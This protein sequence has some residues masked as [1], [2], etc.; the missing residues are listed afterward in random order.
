M[1]MT[2]S[3]DKIEAVLGFTVSVNV[4]FPALDRLVDY[5]QLTQQRDIDSLSGQVVALTSRLKNS[6][7]ALASIENEE[8]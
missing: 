1:R 4:K 5:L 6:N 2:W 8:R 7:D 3:H